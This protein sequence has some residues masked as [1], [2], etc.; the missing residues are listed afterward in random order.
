MMKKSWVKKM[1]GEKMSG[2]FKKNLISLKISA[3]NFEKNH[4]R[5]TQ[6]STR[7]MDRIA[8]SGLLYQK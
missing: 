1:S 2:D 5:P 8:C 4:Y 7:P 3:L 6:L